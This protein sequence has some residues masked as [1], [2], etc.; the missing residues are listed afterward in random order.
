V[1]LLE[2]AVPL[3]TLTGP[4]GVGKTR[5]AKTLA[6]EVAGHFADGVVWVDLASVGDPSLV[7]P[8]IA[9]GLALRDL[10]DQTATEQL[11][12]VLRHRVLLLVL[13]NVEHLLAA[14][15]QLSAL[16]TSCP[17]LQ[18]LV[19]SRSLLSLSGEQDLPVPP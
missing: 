7:L 12:G 4:G 13:D 18:M 2:E 11:I 5:L 14:A 3:L 1:L 16:L 10:G 8:T 17:H 9:H 19:T 15:P 6:Q